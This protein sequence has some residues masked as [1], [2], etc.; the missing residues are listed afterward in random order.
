MIPYRL[1]SSDG[2]AALVE[3][4]PGRVM[5]VEPGDMLPTAGRVVSIERGGD[6]GWVLVTTQRRIE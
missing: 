4:P 6:R 3:G 5:K 1:R 2:R